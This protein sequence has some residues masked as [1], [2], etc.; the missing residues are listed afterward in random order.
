M[1]AGF[2]EIPL[3]SAIMRRSILD[4]EELL[5]IEQGSPAC[6]LTSKK[7]FWYLSACIGWPEGLCTMLE[8]MRV[9]RMVLR[10]AWPLSH[11]FHLRD[12][13]SSDILFRAGFKITYMI[14]E[15][16]INDCRESLH[17]AVSKI[18]QQSNTMQ[19]GLEQTGFTSSMPVQIYSAFH[20]KLT[21]Q[22]AR[23]LYDAGVRTLD[24]ESSEQSH[25]HFQYPT[26]LLWKIAERISIDMRSRGDYPSKLKDQ[27]EVSHWLIDKGVRKEWLHPHY[28]TTPLHLL[29]IA[30]LSGIHATSVRAISTQLLEM[31]N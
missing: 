8:F 5:K 15:H 17:Y 4:F 12:W 19:P 7:L 30:F 27:L 20:I 2:S 23:T 11:A 3:L 24:T 10:D 9:K 18:I 1:H 31:T 28:Q 21:L 29:P 25:I 13:K 26:T 14:F 16:A 6:S 22:A